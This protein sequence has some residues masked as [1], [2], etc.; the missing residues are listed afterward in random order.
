[1]KTIA[2]STAFPARVEEL[3]RLVLGADG[4][5][6]R[7]GYW[8]GPGTWYEE[9]L[10]P[11]PRIHIDEAARRTVEALDATRGTVITLVERD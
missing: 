7:Y 1:V 10:P 3:E 11:E 9:S 6:L 4:V 8:Y 5:V 2:Q